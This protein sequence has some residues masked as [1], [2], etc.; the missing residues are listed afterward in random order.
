MIWKRAKEISKKAQ[1]SVNINRQKCDQLPSNNEGLN[2]GFVGNCWFVAAVTGI[3]ENTDLFKKI[4]PLDNSFSEEEYCGTR[5][6][7]VS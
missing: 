4:F 6:L 2:Q 5:N 3:I 7:V 1:L